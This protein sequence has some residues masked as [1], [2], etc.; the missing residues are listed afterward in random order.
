MTVGGSMDV[1]AAA[2]HRSSSWLGVSVVSPPRRVRLR[3]DA[4]LGA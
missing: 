1:R 3:F 4:R 2:Q